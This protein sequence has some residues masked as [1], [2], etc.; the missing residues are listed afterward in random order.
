MLGLL[1]I[2]DICMCVAHP[3]IYSVRLNHHTYFR[4]WAC[5]LIFV[6]LPTDLLYR[7][8]SFLLSMSVWDVIANT[9]FVS[10]M[11]ICLAFLISIGC[12]VFSAVISFSNNK[13]VQISSFNLFRFTHYLLLLMGSFSFSKLLKDWMFRYSFEFP[14]KSIYIAIILSI[15]IYIRNRHHFHNKFDEL[16]NKLYKTLPVFM[17]LCVLI[18]G[19]RISVTVWGDLREKSQSEKLSSDALS[20]PEV[21]SNIILVTFDALSTADMSAYGYNLNT[22]PNIDAFAKDGL[23]FDSFYSSSNWSLSS[24]VSLFTGVRPDQHMMNNIN[25]YSYDPGTLNNNF[26]KFLKMNG[27]MT[28]AVVGGAAYAHPTATGLERYF[29]RVN[30]LDLRCLALNEVVSAQS[31]RIF[32]F[33]ARFGHLIVGKWIGM[34]LAEQAN[35]IYRLPFVDPYVTG[36]SYSPELMTKQALELVKRQTGQ[37]FFLWVHYFQPH[38]PYVT[39]KDLRGTF[40]KSDI[41]LT[42]SDIHQNVAYRDSE[43]AVINTMRLQYDESI[44]YM[45]SVF[46]ELVSGLK[47]INGYEKNIIIVSADHGESFNNNFIGHNYNCLNQSVINVPLIIGNVSHRP[48]RIATLGSHIDLFPTIFQLAELPKPNWAQGVSLLSETNNKSDN[49]IF[50]MNLDGNPLDGHVTKGHVAVL[51]DKYKFIYNIK[52]KTGRLYDL[53]V[54]KSEKIDISL[55]Y[56][57]IKSKMQ[58]AVIKN[59]LN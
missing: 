24:I 52:T 21:K 46:G 44:L 37:P 19:L 48:E 4:M 49:Y 26:V 55:L 35:Y 45:D 5:Y 10:L 9:A 13:I 39:K 59:I 25:H 31:T 57:D 32:Q 11:L 23:I 29:D 58:K 40:L 30:R 3:R 43:Q 7:I 20:M 34:I 27:Y 16:T 56:P 1:L 50:S 15:L 8:D 47:K 53:Q 6:F 2:H 18:V 36:I 28:Y 33:A 22:T 14:I 38:F 17:M 54:D 12:R 51:H 41:K 42:H